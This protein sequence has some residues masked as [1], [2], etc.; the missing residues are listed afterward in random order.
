LARRGRG[1]QQDLTQRAALAV[2]GRSTVERQLAFARE[3]GWRALTFFQTVGDDYAFDFG[4]LDPASGAE[5]PVIAVFTKHGTGKD[6]AVRLFWKAEMTAAM[7]DA[8]KDPRGGADLSSLWT[9]LDLTPEGRG[10]TWY[11]KLAY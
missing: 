8:G 6:A 9:A 3:R 5:W 2:L 1:I 11:P 7:A 4:G 10:D